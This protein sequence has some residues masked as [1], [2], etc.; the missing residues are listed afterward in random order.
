MNDACFD[1]PRSPNSWW[2]ADFRR[3]PESDLYGKMSRKWTESAVRSVLRR[4]KLCEIAVQARISIV[5]RRVANREGLDRGPRK[6]GEPLSGSKYSVSLA[7]WAV[8]KNGARVALPVAGRALV[9][10]ET[11]QLTQSRR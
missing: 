4:H 10:F 7:L 6:A 3:G 1:H 11:T 8:E 5:S 2:P 9:Y